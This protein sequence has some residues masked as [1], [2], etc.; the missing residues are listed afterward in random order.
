VYANDHRGHGK[1][2][3]SARDLGFFARRK[4]WNRVLEDLRLLIESEREEH[5]GVPAV[6]LGHSLGSFM[7][8]CICFQYEGLIQGCALSGSGGKPG[9]DIWMLRWLSYAERFRV[10]KRGRSRLLHRLSLR[11]A[12]RDFQPVRTDFD[13]LTPDAA[14]VDRFLADPLC[15]F[16]STTQLWTDVFRG[17]YRAARQENRARIPKDLPVYIFSGARDPI[18]N[19]CETLEELIAG[20]HHAG[21]KHVHYKFYP[22]G[23]HEMLNDPNRDAVIEDLLSWLGGVALRKG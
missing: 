2:A 21:L 18:S 6:L 12:N 17:L 9:F 20:Y 4:G 10:G 15:G 19:C 16:V 3:K 14:E 13:W 8:Q 1:T 7:A 23:R 11:R 5:P 22:E